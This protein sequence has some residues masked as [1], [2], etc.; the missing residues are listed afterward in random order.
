MNKTHHGAHARRALLC[1]AV[2]ALLAGLP[3]RRAEGQAFS[4]SIQGTV[5]AQA[6]I[7]D[8]QTV[9]SDRQSQGFNQSVAETILKSGP[10][11]AAARGHSVNFGRTEDLPQAADASFDATAEIGAL[12]IVAL[13]DS[14]VGGIP[15]S[16]LTSAGTGPVLLSWTDTVTFTT[17]NPNGSDFV[18]GLTLHDAIDT[19]FKSP[20]SDGQSFAAGSAFAVLSS[21]AGT[22]GPVLMFLS[23]SVSQNVSTGLTINHPAAGTLTKVIHV[24][25]FSTMVLTGW[26][27]ASA[28]VSDSDSSVSV[29]AGDTALFTINTV[30]P[31]AGYVA[32]SGTVFAEAVPEPASFE[33]A[34]LGLLAV[35]CAARRRR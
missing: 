7:F 13:A 8:G 30:D 29:D 34:G 35:F 4:V 26:I 3:V 33:L 1:L 25:G 22:T 24:N 21:G 27:R 15:N 31:L 14:S 6:V 20:P 16:G 9:K 19:S 32:A 10:I 11:D 2:A 28:G 18:L 23:D 5:Q 12:H 17:S